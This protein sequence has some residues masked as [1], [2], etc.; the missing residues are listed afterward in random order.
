M[1]V[2]SYASH[3]H[4]HTHTVTHSLSVVTIARQSVVVLSFFPPSLLLAICVL[5]S[6]FHSCTHSIPSPPVLPHSLHPCFFHSLVLTQTLH[7]LLVSL[8][9]RRLPGKYLSASRSSSIPIHKLPLT[10]TTF[11]LP[12]LLCM[13]NHDTHHAYLSA[14][15]R[16]LHKLPRCLTCIDTIP[17]HVTPGL[18]VALSRHTS[19][20]PH[21][22]THST[23]FHPI[24]GTQGFD[25]TDCLTM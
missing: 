5:P 18:G 6:T 9:S 14:L 1:R 17:H 7:P 16:L 4:S 19:P 11:P 21:P 23:P 8:T 20:Q 24:T 25:T 15:Q 3:T 13:Q 10:Y 12:R 2:I 22:L